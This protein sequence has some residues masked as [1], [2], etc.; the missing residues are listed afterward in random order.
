M[1]EHELLG[2]ADDQESLKLSPDEAIY[3]RWARDI[4]FNLEVKVPNIDTESEEEYV[5]TVRGS[6][7]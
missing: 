4:G 6:D 1:S 2:N 3:L 5:P 7:R